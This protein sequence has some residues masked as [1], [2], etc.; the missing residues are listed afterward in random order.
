MSLTIVPNMQPSKLEKIIDILGMPERI[1]VSVFPFDETSKELNDAIADIIGDYGYSN[2]TPVEFDLLSMNVKM[3][4]KTLLEVYT[5]NAREDYSGTITQ[6]V[7][8][9]LAYGAGVNIQISELFWCERVVVKQ[10]GYNTITDVP[11]YA[12]FDGYKLY[13]KINKT[14]RPEIYK[15]LK[16]LE[17][18]TEDPVEAVIEIR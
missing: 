11:V 5:K 13:A 17:T 9:S 4:K 6:T 18:S 1:T 7:S 8:P 15:Q 14:I 3:D 12:T 10:G 2:V 16:S